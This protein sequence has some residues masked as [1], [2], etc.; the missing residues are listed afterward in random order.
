MPSG[1]LLPPSDFGKKVISASII[2]R[3]VIAFSL[4]QLPLPVHQLQCVFVPVA[5][6]V[7]EDGFG[8]DKR[9]INAEFM[10][11]AVA[12]FFQFAEA[13]EFRL[14][15]PLRAVLDDEWKFFR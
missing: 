12:D 3:F 7:A 6:E 2:A 8:R 10:R 11:V 13:A 9:G 4:Q 14:A 15:G 1:K 5:G